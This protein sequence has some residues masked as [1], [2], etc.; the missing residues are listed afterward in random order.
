M[1]DQTRD[2]VEVAQTIL[3]DLKAQAEEAE[4][5]NDVD[6]FSLYNELIKVLSPIVTKRFARQVREER[7]RSNAAFK[8]LRAKF[9]EDADRQK[10][11]GGD[12]D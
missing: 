9:R 3:S 10:Q 4:Q 6:S 11:G 2:P 7:A 1:A 8:A 5:A 12:E